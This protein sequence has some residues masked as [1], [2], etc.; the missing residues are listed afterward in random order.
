MQASK[1]L[2]VAIVGLLL[3][4][5][6]FAGVSIEPLIGYNLATELDVGGGGKTYHGGNGIAYGGKLAY[7]M[8]KDHGFSFGLDYLKND[9]DMSDSDID[10][11]INADEWGVYVGFKLPA[12]FKFYGEYIFSA[13]GDTEIEDRDRNLSGGTG[14]KLG[15]GTTIIPFIDINLDY[16]EISY[17]K[18]DFSAVMLS[19]SWPIHLFD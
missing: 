3:S 6:T 17:D 13:Y 16:R 9:V 11:N 10:K 5:T 18:I 7:E 2:T 1:K 19:A 14:W 15:L 4:I 12:L 8:N